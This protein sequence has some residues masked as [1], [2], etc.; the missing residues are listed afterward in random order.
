V[1]TKLRRLPRLAVA[2]STMS[3]QREV[4]RPLPSWYSSQ[5]NLPSIMIELLI[6][7]PPASLLLAAP[8]ACCA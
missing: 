8:S 4:V 7:M 6:S 2:L 5:S 3:M 1:G